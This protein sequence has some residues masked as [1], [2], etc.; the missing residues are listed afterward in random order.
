MALSDN[1]SDAGARGVRRAAAAWAGAPESPGAGDWVGR[2]LGTVPGPEPRLEVGAAFGRG[3]GI[4]PG[5][6]ALVVMA[7]SS[8][9]SYVS[10]FFRRGASTILSPPVVVEEF[11]PVPS[12]MRGDGCLVWEA[13]TS[14]GSNRAHTRSL[15]LLIAS[16]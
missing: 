1:A 7:C 5:T 4:R 12:R 3:V 13:S 10:L 11:F 15:S 6:G 2:W 8:Y 14:G 16:H 9:S